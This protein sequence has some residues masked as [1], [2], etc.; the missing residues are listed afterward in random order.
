MKKKWVF[1]EHTLQ[2]A[3][4]FKLE[5]EIKWKV[6][7]GSKTEILSLAQVSKVIH[8]PG[9]GKERTIAPGSSLQL[10]LVLCCHFAWPGFP[11]YRS[12]L[13]GGFF[14]LSF[15]TIFELERQLA[16][17]GQSVKSTKMYANSLHLLSP[18]GHFLPLLVPSSSQQYVNQIYFLNSSM[19]R[20]AVWK[21]SPQFIC[22]FISLFSHLSLCYAISWTSSK[23]K[24]LPKIHNLKTV[25]GQHDI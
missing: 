22:I 23:L 10:A 20:L 1:L 13:R 17:G 2:W 14:I 12:V 15:L 4:C 5:E 21:K 8:M 9:F 6:W 18:H 11:T 7:V 16:I 24:H 25:F 3:V 19:L